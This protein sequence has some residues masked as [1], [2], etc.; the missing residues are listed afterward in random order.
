[1][2]PLLVALQDTAQISGPLARA[3]DAETAEI[4]LRRFPDGETYLRF[5]TPLE[6]REVILL[7]GLAYPDAKLPA[8]VFAAQTARALGATSVGLVAPYLPYMRQDTM[9]QP[10]ESV[11]SVH[12]AKL[13]SSS[14]DWLVTMDPHLHRWHALSDIYDIPTKVSHAASAMAAWITLEVDKPL[15]IGPD[16]ESKQW[17]SEMAALADADHVILSK[18]RRGDRDVEIALQDLRPWQDHTP[19]LVDDTISTAST[20]IAATRLVLN[21]GLRP[22][23]CCAVHAVFGGDSDK[24]LREAGAARIVTTNTIAHASNRIDISAALAEAV[25]SIRL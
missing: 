2:N 16:S 21:Q 9:F 19:V 3:L 24:A 18:T 5:D 7:A 12:F 23:V 6:G 20:M 13:I 4:D 14:V 11:T 10:G 25:R 22:P 1:M 17:V 8:L 15:L